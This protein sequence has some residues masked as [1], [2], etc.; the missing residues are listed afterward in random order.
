MLI[1]ATPLTLFLVTGGR[2]GSELAPRLLVAGLALAW[3]AGILVAT[4]RRRRDRGGSAARDA[5][6]EGAPPV[7]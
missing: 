6:A 1:V 3:A 4:S 5:R 2:A 7:P